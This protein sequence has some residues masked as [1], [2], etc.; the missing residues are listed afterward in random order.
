MSRVL[1]VEDESAI[2]ELVALNLRHAGFDVTLAETAEQ[3]RALVDRV[4]P[5][6]VLLDWM[7]PG[8]SGLAL[9]KHWREDARTRE[10]PL[11]M[12]TARTDEADRVAGL[13]AGA[14]DYL[15]KP[16][17]L[18][19]LNARLRAIAR[20]AAGRSA[21]L[22]R[23]GDVEIDGAARCVRRAGAAVDL[24]ARELALLLALARR[25]GAT[26]SRAQLAA[27]LYGW[28]EGVDSNAIDVHLHHLRR[29]LGAALIE[30][31]R[32]LGWRLARA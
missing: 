27:A 20:R 30:T 2:A 4:L 9:A 17:D 10:L 3:A 6:L 26:L 7:L 24:T 13:D 5:D 23:I 11:I 25:P 8:G 29:K 28:D 15:V 21:E 18:D 22:V 31:Q 1:V 32:G 12:L 16:L 19:E 14:D